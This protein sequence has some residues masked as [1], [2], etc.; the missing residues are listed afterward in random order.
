L[1]YRRSCLLRPVFAFYPQPPAGNF[2]RLL[3]TRRPFASLP[4]TTAEAL[5]LPPRI[6]RFLPGAFCMWV[7]GV[8]C[9][10]FSGGS[11]RWTISV[12][13]AQRKNR[14]RFLLETR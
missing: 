14:N 11:R 3:I 8:R 10:R 7:R 1:G 6:P 9:W 2:R 13:S 12:L 4:F 5:F